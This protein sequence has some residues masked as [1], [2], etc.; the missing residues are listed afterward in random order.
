M[1]GMSV[2]IDFYSIP[3]SKKE[4]YERYINFPYGCFDMDFDEW[5]YENTSVKLEAYGGDCYINF[6][7]LRLQ[8]I[9]LANI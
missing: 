4:L 6:K 7:P 1:E 9:V 3:K 5:L 2:C 8:I